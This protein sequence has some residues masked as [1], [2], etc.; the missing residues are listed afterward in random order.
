ERAAKEAA[1]TAA[2][3]TAAAESQKK[4]ADA[5][6]ASQKV[7]SK[8]SSSG[9]DNKATTGTVL[10]G[11]ESALKLE[12]RRLQ[13]Y[14]EAVGKDFDS[15]MASQSEYHRHGMQMAR[16]IKTITGSKENVRSKANELLKLMN[17]TCPQAINMGIFADKIFSLCTNANSNST[18]YAYGH[19][20][21]MLT[22]QIPPAMD[23]L[24]AK[25]NRGC[26]LTVPK[27]ISYS[28][29]LV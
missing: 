8:G 17:S 27:Y 7:V 6:T 2:A 10:K 13:M 19:V 15:K 23:I 26:I 11:A 1:D 16:H 25:L 28:E 14:N 24:I 18:L 29:V 9:G 5:L 20:I 21:V 4:A 3:D 22:S 12:E